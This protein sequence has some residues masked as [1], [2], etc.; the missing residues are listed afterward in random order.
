MLPTLIL[1]LAQAL[2]SAQAPTPTV[3]VKDLL[4]L[5]PPVS[6]AEL[7]QILTLLT[8]VDDH[9]LAEDGQL[10][11]YATDAEQALLRE[12]GIPFAVQIEDLTAFYADRLAADLRGRTLSVGSMGGWRTL[13]EIE[14]MRQAY[15]NG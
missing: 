12:A 4:H 10:I 15:G 14:Q 11:A 8:D 1:A 3:P 6:E 5:P 13:A 7:K 2:P 9:A